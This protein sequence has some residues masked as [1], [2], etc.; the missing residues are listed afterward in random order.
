MAF[1]RDA[2]AA[3]LAATTMDR[4]LGD[5]RCALQLFGVRLPDGRRVEL[6]RQGLAAFWPAPAPGVEVPAIASLL[7]GWRAM[8][9]A[10]ALQRRDRAIVV[11]T[12][13][14]GLRP[15]D[16]LAI[17]RDQDFPVFDPTALRL[18]LRRDKGSLLSGRPASRWLVLC[19]HPSLPVK[20]AVRWMLDDIPRERVYPAI[21]PSGVFFPAFVCYDRAKYGKPLEPATIS[22]ILRRFLEGLGLQGE[23]SK[24]HRIRSYAASAAYELGVDLQE[25]CLHFRWVSSSTFLDHYYLRG[26]EVPLSPGPSGPRDGSRVSRAFAMALERADHG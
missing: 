26:V 13:M 3:G 21:D 10:T 22:R 25:L 19:D 14:L 11:L 23:R 15:I 5:L 6:L 7:A 9:S 17:G 20:E 2:A 18:R 12:I 1:L 16:L 8:P 24:A 4:L